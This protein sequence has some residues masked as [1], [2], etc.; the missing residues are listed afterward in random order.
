MPMK[1]VVFEGCFGWLHAANGNRGV[2][3]CNAFGHEAVWSH[4]GIRH[5]AEALS[6]RGVSVL[7]FDYRGTGDSIGAD[8][9][10][11]QLETAVADVRA[12]IEELKRNT[13]VTHVTLC[14][15]R[16]GAALAV[17]AARESSV[18]ELVLLAPVVSGR[19]YVRELS[20]V[21]KTWFDQLAA[22]V[23]AAQPKDA[24]LNVL[25]QVYGKEFQAAL[26]ALDL[27]R[28]LKESVTR[29]ATRAL[30]FDIRPGASEPLRTNLGVLGVEVECR[31]FDGYIAFLQETAFSDMPDSVFAATIDWI[32]GGHSPE[33]GA[34]GAMPYSEWDANLTIKTP[35]SIEYPVRIGEA[36]LFGILA[37]PRFARV[38]GPVLLITNTS[39]SAHVGDSRL[40]VRVAREM[41]RQGIPSLR[42]D[43]RGIGD[44]P[45]LPDELS[46]GSQFSAIYSTN[47]VDDVAQAAAWLKEQGYEGVVSFGVCSGAY[48]AVRAA[49]VTSALSGAIA[50]NIQSFYM[51]RGFTP[52]SIAKRELNSVAG[53]MSSMFQLSRWKRIFSGQRSLMPI[54]RLFAGQVAMRVRSRVV[55]LIR[56]RPERAGIDEV[57]SDPRGVVS[58]LQRKGVQTLLVYGAFDSGLDILTAHFGKKGRRL[59][60]FPAVRPAIFDDIDHSLF[61]PAASERVTALTAGFLK[62]LHARERPV[63][64]E[65]SP[66]GLRAA[67]DSER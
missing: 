19:S 41:A 15:F 29:L 6:A 48:S 24:P 46:G 31:P 62:G 25:G 66:A 55:D 54:F 2:V 10:S 37:K 7:R 23:R 12:A 50:V 52:E 43:A 47:T 38:N 40:S 59:S 60:R 34:D 64:S 21:R 65:R 36:G 56:V 16:L 13:G 45:A 35:E 67:I 3:L 61:G 58:A 5:L 42:F 20:I 1:P 39:A 22:T 53:Y 26:S 4:K 9:A 14:G 27:G 44:S 49:L 17:L 51:P 30:I 63:A 33:H 28:E 32:M 11:D 18:D 8:G 57:P